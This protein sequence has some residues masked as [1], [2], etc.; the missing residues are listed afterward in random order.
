M[1]DNWLWFGNPNF[2]LFEDKKN[3]LFGIL[4]HLM[5]DPNRSYYDAITGIPGQG[6][7]YRSVVTLN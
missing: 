6:M 4:I 1:F 7:H 5:I 2:S 3:L